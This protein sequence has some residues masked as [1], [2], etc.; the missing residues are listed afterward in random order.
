MITACLSLLAG[1]YA[2][3]F[4]SFAATSDLILVALFG[5]GVGLSIGGRNAAALFA[6]GLIAFVWQ[7]TAVL[8]SR[9]QT[10]FEGDSMLAAVRII[11]FPRTRGGSVSFLAEPVDDRRI[12]QR[13][14]LSWF[15]PPE[16]PDIGDVWEL[17]LR[18]K[19]PRGTSNPGIFD[20]ETWLFQQ[21]IGATG[22]I[23]NGRRNQLLQTDA[24]GSLA[25]LRKRLTTRLT[26]VADDSETAAVIAAITV[27]A[28]HLITDEQWT[29]YARSGT[30]HLMAISGLHVGLAATAAYLLALLGSMLVRWPG[31]HTRIALFISLFVATAYALLSGFAVPAQRSILMLCLL[32]LVLLRAREPSPFTILAAACALVVIGN[33]LSTLT[34]GFKLSFG[35]VVLLLWLARRRN[36]TGGVSVIMRVTGVVT[37]LAIMQLFLLAGLMPLTVTI[38]H[39]IAIVAPAINMAAV[40][41]FSFVT[42]PFSLIGLLLDGPLAEL[43]DL[44]LRVAASSVQ[45][46]EYLIR[47]S[48]RLP[49]SDI[50]TA[51]IAGAGTIILGL[52]LAWV[53][54]PQGWPGRHVTWLAACAVL[55]YRIE[56]PP[57]GC[58]DTTVLDVGQGLAIVVRTREKTLLYDT[59]ATWPGGASMA[60]RV[61]LPYLSGQGIDRIDRV[62]VSHSDIDHAGGL[63]DMLAGTSVGDVIS[64]EATDTSAAGTRRCHR[65]DNWHW[66]G[67]G[68]RILH[69]LPGD[70]LE[71]NDAS[72]VLAIE[73][74]AAR[75]LITGDIEAGVER[76]LLQSDSNVGSDV[77]VVPHHGSRTSSSP[78]FVA[79]VE[80]HVALISAG[81]RNR[82]DLPRPDVVRR[83]RDVGAEVL[84]TAVEG[85][86]GVRLCDGGG[87]IDLDRH[88]NRIRRVWH[89]VRVD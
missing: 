78:R 32:V 28:R 7:T 15:Q 84:T 21:R 52:V 14:R 46:I 57:D 34:A 51:D 22:Y 27:G 75:L 80:P 58:F 19:R 73:A 48:L 53:L 12:P 59:G 88:R 41:L 49:Y 39:R 4:T 6:V 10:R 5:G 9:L 81:Y 68:F 43:G 37:Q 36:R 45:L 26:R 23:V 87:I 1:A 86:I 50:N 33:P 8:E 89:E 55:G 65:G 18:L 24:A 63:T 54:L 79:T 29:R 2:L 85:A 72:C 61:V 35:A 69:P 11:D 70:A 3:H 77:V 16:A 82:W 40:P 56:V 67:V 66:N 31:N 64:G 25:R 62:V 60:E 74:G 17:E 47:L 13:I 76:S 30:S 42:V 20:Y 83:W 44:A 71:G 38:F